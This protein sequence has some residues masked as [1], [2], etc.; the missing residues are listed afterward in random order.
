MRYKLDLLY[1]P[2]KLIVHFKTINEY[3]V[4]I[5]MHTNIIFV[6]CLLNYTKV[7]KCLYTW[8]LWYSFESTVNYVDLVKQH[9]TRIHYIYSW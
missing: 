2:N 3:N 8:S 6:Y 7:S 5:P 9:L 4:S 1:W